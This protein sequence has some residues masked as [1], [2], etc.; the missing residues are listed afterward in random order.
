MHSVKFIY[1]LRASRK[2]ENLR[3]GPSCPSSL[4]GEKNFAQ[5]TPIFI[6]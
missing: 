4:R 2:K 1:I 6:P 3:R 5:Q